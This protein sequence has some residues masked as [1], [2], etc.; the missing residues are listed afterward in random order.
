MVKRKMISRTLEIESIII[1]EP[2]M[3]IAAVQICIRSAERDALTVS[4]S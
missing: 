4:T 2:T 1:N 3:V